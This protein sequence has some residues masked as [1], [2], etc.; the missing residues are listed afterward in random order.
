MMREARPHPRLPFIAVGIF[1]DPLAA[2]LGLDRSPSE[3][4]TWCYTIDGDDGYII[5]RD[6]ECAIRAAEETLF[7]AR[8]DV[9][10]KYTDLAIRQQD[11]EL[12]MALAERQ[13]YW[14][15]VAHQREM[16]ARIVRD[17]Q[18]ILQPLTL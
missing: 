3:N 5:V 17:A 18:C 2:S 7:A 8:P 9:V 14:E 15:A 13:G 1:V 12:A 16:V 4:T 6:E 10:R 11:F